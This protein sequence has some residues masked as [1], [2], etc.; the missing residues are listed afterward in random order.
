[1]VTMVNFRTFTSNGGVASAWVTGTSTAGGASV[2]DGI[3]MNGWKFAATTTTAGSSSP[4]STTGA[5]PTSVASKSSSTAASSDTSS[6]NIGAKQSSG[7]ST[8]AKAGIGVACGLVGLAIVA[9]AIL[10]F[11]L[12]KRRENASAGSGELDK[13][14]ND[15]YEPPPPVQEMHAATWRAEMMTNGGH[16]DRAELEGNNFNDR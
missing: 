14:T 11:V 9:G 6:P 16:Q 5:A 10:Y 7:L 15:Y 4:T 13:V 12:R 1:M 8:G 3:Q 2:V